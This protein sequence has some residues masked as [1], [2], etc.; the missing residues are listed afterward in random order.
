MVVPGWLLRLCF[1]RKKCMIRW[2]IVRNR[3]R[4]GQVVGMAQRWQKPACSLQG[5]T[6][7]CIWNNSDK[8]NW[9]NQWP[10]CLIFGVVA[11]E[12]PGLKWQQFLIAWR[13]IQWN[14]SHG[15]VFSANTELCY[16][17]EQVCKIQR[18]LNKT[19]MNTNTFKNLLR[20]FIEN[21]DNN[22]SWQC[23]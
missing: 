17:I 13:N 20:F 19:Q 7:I 21:H 3:F 8:T 11:G 12:W 4:T 1:T 10:A 23:Q 9:I 2:I 15:F 22:L 16:T 14:L 5:L 18:L 6:R